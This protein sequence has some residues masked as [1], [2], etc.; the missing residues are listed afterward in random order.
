MSKRSKKKKLSSY[1]ITK[2]YKSTLRVSQLE[3]KNNENNWPN[4]KRLKKNNGSFMSTAASVGG[5]ETSENYNTQTPSS[6]CLGS[7]AEISFS[8]HSL[9]G[10]QG[11][12]TFSQNSATKR[13]QI[14]G[15]QT[16]FEGNKTSNIL[17]LISS[18]SQS[19]TSPN[20]THTLKQFN[21][22]NCHRILLRRLF[23]TKAISL[24][25]ISTSKP[26]CH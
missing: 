10:N 25:S 18:Q 11:S 19:S 6:N 15:Y 16:T 13:S 8:G 1:S 3:K 26:I 21:L 17:F 14:L 23:T 5:I 22:V 20:S 4:S 2:A 9:S 24:N 7:S 12:S